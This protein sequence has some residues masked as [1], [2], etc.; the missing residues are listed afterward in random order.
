MNDESLEL[1]LNKT[2]WFGNLV[3]NY[4]PLFGGQYLE[5]FQS[6]M[7]KSIDLFII[8]AIAQN[9]GC[10]SME[11]VSAIEDHSPFSFSYIQKQKEQLTPYNGFL[12][13]AFQEIAFNEYMPAEK[14]VVFEG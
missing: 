1:K 2:Y 13:S 10:Y 7:R 6:L 4:L 5:L 12:L 11:Y 9:P 14:E 8:E 3:M